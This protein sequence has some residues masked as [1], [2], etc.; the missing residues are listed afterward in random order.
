MDIRFRWVDTVPD[1]TIPTGILAWEHNDPFFEEIDEIFL[2]K[3]YNS[4]YK[5]YKNNTKK[6][7]ASKFE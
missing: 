7:F 1:G 3:I 5:N 6:E 2:K 4:F